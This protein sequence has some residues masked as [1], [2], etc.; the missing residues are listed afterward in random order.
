MTGTIRSWPDAQ[1][2]C[3]ECLTPHE[4]RQ[5]PEPPTRL[6]VGEIFEFYFAR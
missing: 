5:R 2:V 6:Q 4:L 1:L 3:T